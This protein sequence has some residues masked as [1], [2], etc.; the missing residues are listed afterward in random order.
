MK[1]T[2][3]LVAITFA[4]ITSLTAF[5]G[6]KTSHSVSIGDSVMVGNTQLKAG[7]YKVEWEGTGPIVQVNFM[8]DG[9]SIATLP[10]TFQMNDPKVKQDQ[11]LTDKGNSST[12][13]VE[14]D[15]GHQK[16]SLVFTQSGM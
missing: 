3:Y 11:V 10:A 12:T 13:L 14:I 9:K 16:E 1:H 6:S 15:F 5:A 8:R 4:L 2:K 7:D